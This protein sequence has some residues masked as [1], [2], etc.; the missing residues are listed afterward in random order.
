[1]NL[2]AVKFF[3][4]VSLLLHYGKHRRIVAWEVRA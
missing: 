3:V 4:N 2:T 1:M